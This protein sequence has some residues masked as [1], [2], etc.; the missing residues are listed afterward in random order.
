MAGGGVIFSG[1]SP[2][3]ERLVNITNIPFYTAPMSRGVVPEDHVVSF[4]GARSTAM[5][6]AD[7]VLVVGTRLNW[8]MNYGQ[9]LGP[10]AKIIQ[11]DIESS[12]IGHNRDVALGIVAD[13]KLAL[14]QMV[15]EAEAQEA[16]F[17]GA[18]ESPWIVRL[19]EVNDQASAP[20]RSPPSSTPM[21]GPYT[22]FEYARRSRS[23]ST[24]T[25]SSA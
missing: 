9:R 13:A 2:E 7:V 23:S 17:A 19:G 5:R 24:A 11:I 14:A 16:S 21:P 4:P 8:M 25:L 3:L 12:E 6:E 22:P 10:D 1:G 18:L 15:A 20:K